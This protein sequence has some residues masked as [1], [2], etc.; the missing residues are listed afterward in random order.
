[1][2]HVHDKNE[3]SINST[4]STASSQEI[5]TDKLPGES[6]ISWVLEQGGATGTNSLVEE[7]YSGPT[8]LNNEK[9]EE[10]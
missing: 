1:M 7:S 4:S 6:E 10:S 2:I 3:N 9:E 8:N 5:E